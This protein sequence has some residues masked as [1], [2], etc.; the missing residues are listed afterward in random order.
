[1]RE[2]VAAEGAEVLAALG[3][4]TRRRVL[5]LLTEHGP[6][7]ASTLAERVDISRQGLTKHLTTLVDAGVLTT[8]RV[9]REVRYAASP[10]ALEAAAAWLD[11]RARQW[12]AQ[13]A[14]LKQA[15]EGED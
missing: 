6:A 1:M 9:G 7:S 8:G 5:D 15:A 14:A 12:D 11:A 3:D 10:T 4:P 13:L 2:P